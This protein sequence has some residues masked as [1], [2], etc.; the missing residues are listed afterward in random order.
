MRDDS[1]EPPPEDLLGIPVELLS[2]TSVN[3]TA[4]AVPEAT[5]TPSPDSVVVTPPKTKKP[6][7]EDVEK[8]A[9]DA[10]VVEER[11]SDAGIADAGTDAATDAAVVDGGATALDAAV[12]SSDAAVAD[13]AT[14]EDRAKRDPFAVAGNFPTPPKTNV[15]VKVHLFT[16]GIQK[17]PAGRA[18]AALLATEPQWRDFLGPGGL[19][20]IVDLSRIA[21]Y[22]PQLVDSSKVAVFLEYTIETK[23]VIRAVDELVRNTPGARW[24]KEGGKRVAYVK[25]ASADR[26]VIFF[27]GKLI[28]I[29]PPGP[30]A[31]QLLAAKGLPALP[32][33]SDTGEVFQGFLR[34]PHRVRLFRRLGIEIPASVSEG[35]LFLS[36]LPNGGATAQ[37]ELV[38]GSPELAK[39]HVDELERSASALTLGLLRM[40]WTTDGASIHAEARLS[41]LQIAALFGQITKEV[42]AAR[43]GSHQ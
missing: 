25:A 37:L 41:A 23:D 31:T 22:G 17:H 38:D 26:V 29:V 20:P 30:V 24:A 21:I 16:G 3:E 8:S 42:E 18:I 5:P 33:P 28:A 12:A 9:L 43:R 15:N 11:P 32:E 19:D 40:N 4:N 35:R 1:A 10:G 34:T 2:N 13:A 39:A 14:G 27:P 7:P 36:T 6:K